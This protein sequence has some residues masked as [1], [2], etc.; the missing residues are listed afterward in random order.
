M[1]V[2]IYLLFGRRTQHK[3]ARILFTSFCFFKSTLIYIYQIS[4]FMYREKHG[5]I[6]IVK[7]GALADHK[8]VTR[9][10]L[11]AVWDTHMTIMEYFC[12]SPVNYYLGLSS[13]LSWVTSKRSWR[14]SSGINLL[15]VFILFILDC[16]KKTDF[17]YIAINKIL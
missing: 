10:R 1:V 5:Y 9:R 14:K 16:I 12:I 3:L 4:T 17:Y 13:Q 15:T 6:F 11:C 2:C 8:K 7:G